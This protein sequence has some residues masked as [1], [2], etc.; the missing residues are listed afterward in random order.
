LL[1]K[2]PLGIVEYYLKQ[3][4]PV[5]DAFRNAVGIYHNN[6]NNNNNNN[7]ATMDPATTTRDDGDPKKAVD[8]GAPGSGEKQ[9]AAGPTEFAEELVPRASEDGNT[10]TE[11]EEE[12][13]KEPGS[14]FEKPV[15]EEGSPSEH[16]EIDEGNAAQVVDAKDEDYS[17]EVSCC[18][19]DMPLSK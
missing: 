15:S 2:I 19:M 1:R 12:K 3:N 16:D 11:S 4:E 7:T 17:W 10:E 18:G 9:D 13:G 14:L 8:D 5:L 6:N